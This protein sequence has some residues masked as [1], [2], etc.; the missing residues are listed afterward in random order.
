M[1]PAEA[2]LLRLAQEAMQWLHRLD[3][4]QPRDAEALMAWL[5][6]SPLHVREFLLAAAWDL[7]LCETQYRH[8]S[9]T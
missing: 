1:T 8:A 9:C 3:R 4:A 6:Q 2:D 7:A 5:R